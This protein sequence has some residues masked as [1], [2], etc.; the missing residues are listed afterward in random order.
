MRRLNPPRPHRRSTPVA[1]KA[2]DLLDFSTAT[3][4]QKRSAWR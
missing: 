1:L 4:R 3:Q 2:F